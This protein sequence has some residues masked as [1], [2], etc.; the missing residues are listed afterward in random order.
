MFEEE[1]LSGVIKRALDMTM[2]LL[3]E[4]FTVI[5]GDVLIPILWEITTAILGK[6]WDAI[7]DYMCNVFLGGTLGTII[8]WISGFADT[9]GKVWGFLS[10]VFG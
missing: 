4:Y 1:G 2:N 5:M 7:V 8:G 9:L 3:W 10:D 6:I